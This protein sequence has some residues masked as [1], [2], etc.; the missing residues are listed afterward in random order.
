MIGACEPVRVRAYVGRSQ[1]PGVGE[2][3]K[4]QR[5][6][7]LWRGPP[8]N[9]LTLSTPIPA[10]RYAMTA[11]LS[12]SMAACMEE[13]LCI[14]PSNS[15]I[16]LRDKVPPSRI[17]ELSPDEV[18]DIALMALK[19]AGITFVEQRERLY[20][21]MNVPTC[22]KVRHFTSI[23]KRFEY[24]SCAR[25]T[26]SRSRTSFSCRRLRSSRGSA[27]PAFHTYSRATVTP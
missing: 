14:G 1:E 22:V 8:L 11:A 21:R 4:I 7:E 9:L 13:K 15:R 3:R 5:K 18:V 27:S 19:E 20:R 10:Y 16:P 25:I 24:S 26:R 12:T 6:N 17:L 23:P 2:R